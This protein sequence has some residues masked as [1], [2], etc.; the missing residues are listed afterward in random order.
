MRWI[1]L[2]RRIQHRFFQCR[3]HQSGIIQCWIFPCRLGR[4]LL[5]TFI[6]DVIT[7]TQA[8]AFIADTG[9]DD[10]PGLLQFQHGGADGINTFTIDSRKPFERVKSNASD[11]Y[12]MLKHICKNGEQ[13]DAMVLTHFD[14]D[15]IMGMFA[16]L[17][18]AQK[19]NYIPKIAA[20]YLNTGKGY[21]KH[22]QSLEG[23]EPLPEETVKIPMTDAPG[24]SAND[25]K[26][27]TD[28]LQEYGLEEHICSYIVQSCEEIH[29][30]NAKCY[31]IS[32][33]DASLKDLIQ[34]FSDFMQVSPVTPYGGADPEWSKP[35]DELSGYDTPE[36]TSLSNGASIA[37][38]FEFEKIRIAFL[39]DA[40]PSVCIDGLLKLGYSCKKPCCVDLVK[41][42]HHGSKYNCSD[43]LFQ[44]LRTQNYL[45]STDGRSGKLPNKTMI[46]KLL[47]SCDSATIYCNYSWW[48]KSIYSS[49]FTEEDREKWLV[50]GNLNLIELSSE[51]TSE[52][53]KSGLELYGFGRGW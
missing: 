36:D 6:D 31:I 44:I 11:F 53:V 14:Q 34:N 10:I 40:Y 23:S 50:T 33:S 46:A 43:K 47:H 1:F 41:L 5:R 49:F 25:L 8:S 51:N 24:Y 38:L 42:S 35:L 28:F 48:K 30:G 26:K 16:G 19:K 27:L 9:A 20:L 17:Q 2:R 39:G 7:G 12:E 18:K 13:I 3:L 29:I 37:F 22:H 15:H 21:W 52:T 4:L 32:P 45:L